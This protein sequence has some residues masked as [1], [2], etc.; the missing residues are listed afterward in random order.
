MSGYCSIGEAV[1]D[2][3]PAST[4]RIEITDDRIGRSMK[5]CVNI[6]FSFAAPARLWPA[7]AASPGSTILTGAPATTRNAPSTTTRSPRLQAAHDDDVLLALVVADHHRA[8]LGVTVLL[9]DVD[10]V[11]VGA[12]LHRE[13]RH[14]DRVLPRAA[15]HLGRHE[16]AGP[17]GL[18]R[19]RQ[20]RAHQ[21]RPRVLAEGRV[22]EVDAPGLRVGDA[23][24]H[25]DLHLEV[26]VRRQR[27]LL[28]LHQFLELGHLVLR[29]AEVHPHRIERGD[30]GELGTVRERVDVGALALQRAAHQAGHRRAD[31]GVAEVELLLRHLRLRGEHRGARRVE[32]ALRLVEVSLRQGAL[33]GERLHALE[34]RRRRGVARLLRE[35]LALRRLELRLERLRIDL[36]QHLPLLDQLALLVGDLVEEAGNA[37]HDVH[38][39]RALGLRDE[40][41]DVRDRLRLHG[42]HRDLRCGPLLRRRFLGAGSR[43]RGSQSGFP[44]ANQ[45]LHRLP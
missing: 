40:A 45:K 29:H 6:Y 11:T 38:L 12:L 25:D 14:D 41:L 13:L 37:R 9:D 42:H 39:L 36:E 19:V 26:L 31:G 7:L 1:I 30:V 5:K 32:L 28:L 17:Q 33:L 2:T 21:E 8:Q 43:Q 20:R 16:H 34:I 22:G 3:T 15:L 27:E 10:Q 44:G 23:V 18:L 24:G 35:Q 4:I